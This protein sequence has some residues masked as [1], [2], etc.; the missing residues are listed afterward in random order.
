MNLDEKSIHL[1]M[2]SLDIYGLP[3]SRRI[4]TKFLLGG[5]FLYARATVRK[6]LKWPL[7][8]MVE[9]KVFVVNKRE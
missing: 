3:T 2:H 8:G 7:Y 5:V 6:P 4:S 9:G 1:Y